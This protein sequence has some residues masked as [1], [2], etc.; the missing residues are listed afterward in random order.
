[1]KIIEIY[2]KY[3]INQGLQ[4]HM[5]RVAAVAQMIC[6]NATEEVD[7]KN[8]ITACLVH[9]L[10]NLIKAQ[11]DTLP[12]L[13]EPEGVEYWENI[14]KE[15]IALYGNDVH[16]ATMHMV[17]DINLNEQAHFYFGSIGNEPTA[18]VQAEDYIGAKIANYSDMRVGLTGVLSLSERMD[19][20]RN[21]YVGRQMNDFKLEVINEREH[22]LIEIEK[23]I[24]SRS[25]I[26]P[27]D[28]TD[29]ST[30]A[31]QKELWDF[32]IPLA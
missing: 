23:Y 24:F 12:E 7:T 20:I 11:M 14:Q 15:M 29:E 8:V 19:D 22:L 25:N 17:N 3:K 30:S 13:F 10:G 5:I 18:Q 6:E 32:D 28:I 4:E 9:D 16:A 27:E 2:Q 1:M 21:R 31:I 26:Q